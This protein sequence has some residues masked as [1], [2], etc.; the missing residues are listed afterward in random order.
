MI[1]I[2]KFIFVLIISAC[3]D[4][5]WTFAINY[6]NKRSP[7]IAS[8]WTGLGYLLASLNIIEYVSDPKLIIAVVIG[9]SL[10]CF[11]TIKYLQ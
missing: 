11:F 4:S 7:T 1:E 2:F 5:C 6:T 8:I 3:L 9:A 10:G